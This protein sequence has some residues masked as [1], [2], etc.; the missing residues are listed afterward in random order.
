SLRLQ[1]LYPKRNPP[2]SCQSDISMNQ[3]LVRR[4]RADFFPDRFQEESVCVHG[5]KA[6]IEPSGD[7]RATTASVLYV[8][9]TISDYGHEEGQRFLIKMGRLGNVKSTQPLGDK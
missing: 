4:N 7:N 2:L 6:L 9:A 5:N 8:K 1:A 3:T